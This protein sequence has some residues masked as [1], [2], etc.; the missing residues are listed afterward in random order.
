M[1]KFYQ[2]QQD[3]KFRE[4]EVFVADDT[5]D[6]YYNGKKPDIKGFSI[7]KVQLLPGNTTRSDHQAASWC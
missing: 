3:K 7:E 2:L 6:L 4:A 1:Q 5:K